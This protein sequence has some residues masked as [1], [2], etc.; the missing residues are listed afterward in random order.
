[1]PSHNTFQRGNSTPPEVTSNHTTLP[2][3]LTCKWLGI[4]YVGQ[5]SLC[6]PN[7]SMETQHS[8]AV[9]YVLYAVSSSP[10]KKP[11]TVT[12]S[13]N[14]AA[15]ISF[16]V[17]LCV[18]GSP[19]CFFINSTMSTKHRILLGPIH[20]GRATRRKQMGPVDVNGG[21]HTARK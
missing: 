19:T 11:T 18:E 8:H 16:S 9:W 2:P 14:M 10:L 6:R 7:V 12:S 1:M 15:L 3:R 4:F 17:S 13:F 21:V 20:T 5:F